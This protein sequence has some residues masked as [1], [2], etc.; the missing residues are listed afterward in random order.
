MI[1]VLDLKLWELDQNN[2]AVKFQ[3]EG[4]GAFW[5]GP[6]SKRHGK[7]DPYFTPNQIRSW[8]NSGANVDAFLRILDICLKFPGMTVSFFSDA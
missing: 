3:I 5:V 6:E 4:N 7:L 1:A 8:W 2:T